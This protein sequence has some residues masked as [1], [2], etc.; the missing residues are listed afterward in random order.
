M[1]RIP[2]RAPE[3]SIRTALAP[4][5]SIGPA[6]YDGVSSRELPPPRAHLTAETAQSRSAQFERD[7][8]P[9]LDRIYCAALCMTG[10]RA[11]AEDLVQDAFARAH[12]SFHEFRPGRNLRAWLFRIL[13]TTFIEAHQKPGGDPSAGRVG[14]IDD[15]R[16][17][18]VGSTRQPARHSAEAQAQLRDADVRAVLQSMPYDLRITVYLAD[19]EDFSHE[20]IGQILG[21]PITTVRSRLHDGHRQLCIWLLGA[22]RFWR[23]RRTSDGAAGDEH[24]ADQVLPGSAAGASE[25]A[26]DHIRVP[27]DRSGATC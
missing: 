14:E 24:H 16:L 5:L 25:P 7:A 4:I 13:T 22:H 18:R 6:P 19:V 15:R 21:I 9:H 2:I 27:A 8:L 26:G 3:V 20:E 12:L 11:N 1:K 23:L 17:E 10:D